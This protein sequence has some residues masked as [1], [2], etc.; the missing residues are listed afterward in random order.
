MIKRATNTETLQNPNPSCA[1]STARSVAA[2]LASR[3]LAE[4]FRSIRPARHPANAEDIEPSAPNDRY[5]VDMPRAAPS[6]S[7]PP[8]KSI[9]PREHRRGN[10]QPLGV[11]G[12]LTEANS[13]K[14]LDVNVLNVS[15]HGCAFRS[16]VPHRPGSSYAMRIGTGPLHL[17][18]TIRIISS[19][20][21]SDGFYDIGAKFV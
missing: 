9:R 6:A 21:R 20:D 16:P 12:T 1:L 13:D 15:L 7:G 10:R 5:T 17:T 14:Q 11:I 4:A 18:S 3:S 8:A 2:T 19:R